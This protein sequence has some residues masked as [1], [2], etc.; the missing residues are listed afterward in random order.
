MNCFCR[1]GD[2]QKALTFK[3]QPHKIVK[4]TQTIRRKSGRIVLRVFDHFVG[5]VLKGLSLNTS[6][7]HCQRLSSPQSPLT[8]FQQDL[9][10]AIPGDTAA[11][12]NK[13]Y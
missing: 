9:D 1:M 5:L 10:L 4:H 7:N 11:S 3:S 6:R 12:Q 2:R 8:S 13:N